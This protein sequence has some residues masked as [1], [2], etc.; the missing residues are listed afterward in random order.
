M[1]KCV[2]TTCNSVSA[3]KLARHFEGNGN[4]VVAEGGKDVPFNISRTFIVFSEKDAIRGQ[5]AHK[6]CAQFLICLNGSIEVYCTDGINSATFLLSSPNDGLY[7][8]TGIWAEQRYKV[9]GSILLVLCE[10]H[11]ESDDYIRDYEEFLIYR[12]DSFESQ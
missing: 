10:R 6:T 12:H 2:R 9:D 11:Y 1:K 4:L 3:V 5:H 7:V 8:P